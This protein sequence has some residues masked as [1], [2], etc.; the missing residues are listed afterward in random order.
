MYVRTVA[1]TMTSGN[2]Y[3]NAAARRRTPLA[4]LSPNVA[5][6]SSIL[7][8]ISGKLDRLVDS[9]NEHKG[10]ILALKAQAE[11]TRKEMNENFLSMSDKIKQLEYRLEHCEN[12][13]TAQK[14][15]TKTKVPRQLAVSFCLFF[16]CVAMHGSYV[17]IK[18]FRTSACTA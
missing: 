11:D 12:R 10:S 4:T 1:C 6:T 17:H 9:S 2:F 8:A 5:E 7:T 15:A 13:A 14:A 3:G 18:Y 16:V